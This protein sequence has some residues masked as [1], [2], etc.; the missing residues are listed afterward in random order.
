LTRPIP[1]H[2]AGFFSENPPTKSPIILDDQV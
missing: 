2:A 1:F